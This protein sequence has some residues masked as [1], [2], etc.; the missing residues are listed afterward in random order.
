MSVTGL[1]YARLCALTLL[2]GAACTS[3][4]VEDSETADSGAEATT[5]TSSGTGEAGETGE[6]ERK[7]LHSFFDRHDECE[8][9]GFFA[10]SSRTIG[11][12]LAVRF[13][14]P[15]DTWTGNPDEA[16]EKSFAF[17][18]EELQVALWVSP[19]RTHHAGNCQTFAPPDEV[20]VLPAV[21]GRADAMIRGPGCIFT[22][23][24]Y[25][26]DWFDMEFA[27]E[28]GE[29]YGGEFYTPDWADPA[30]QQP[31]PPAFP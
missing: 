18:N 8:S 31:D 15:D 16:L 1:G 30:P 20:L 23:E 6:T 26:A 7:D 21:A 19:S 28:A 29:V 3:S 17:P 12:V 13:P 22:C 9:G 5:E 24:T 11:I 14:E 25:F 4:G 27:S 2:L 10:W